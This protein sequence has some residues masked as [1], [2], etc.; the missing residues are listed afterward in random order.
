[1]TVENGYGTNT[2]PAYSQVKMTSERAYDRKTIKAAIS[3][4]DTPLASQGLPIRG[5]ERGST[6]RV[7]GLNGTRTRG[8]SKKFWPWARKTDNRVKSGIDCHEI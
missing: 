6:G 5:K 8:T 1:M 7:S 4:A 3:A 2:S